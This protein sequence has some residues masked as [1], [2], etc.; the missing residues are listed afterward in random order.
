MAQ[1]KCTGPKTNVTYIAVLSR[2]DPGHL[3]CAGS[4]VSIQ[5][6]SSKRQREGL[7]EVE[8]GYAEMADGEVSVSTGKRAREL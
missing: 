1:R 6:T 5:K 3:T 7:V 4:S 2:N 8:P